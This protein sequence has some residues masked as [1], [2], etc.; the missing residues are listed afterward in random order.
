L[1]YEKVLQLKADFPD[2]KFTIN[3]GIKTIEKA[4]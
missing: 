3:G 2:L 1:Q 4:K